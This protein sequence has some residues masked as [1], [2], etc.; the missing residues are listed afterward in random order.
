MVKLI[1]GIVDTNTN[2]LNLISCSSSS[3]N[4]PEIQEEI[5]DD[6][7][8]LED[9]YNINTEEEMNEEENSFIE[10]EGFIFDEYDI[11]CEN[12]ECK[13]GGKLPKGIFFNNIP[14]CLV[15]YISG[16]R[17]CLYSKNIYHIYDMTQIA[18]NLYCHNDNIVIMNNY[19]KNP[20]MLN[21]FL[22]NE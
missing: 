10:H 19:I 16:Y 7:D 5:D 22:L 13:N 17:P 15:C 21:L 12:K 6:N 3:I 14:L 11:E 18:E 4:I 8:K 20:E 9:I 1:D 2:D